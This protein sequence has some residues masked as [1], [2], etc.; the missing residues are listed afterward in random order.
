MKNL[1]IYLSITVYS[2]L[3]S[4]ISIFPV[5]TDL[6]VYLNLFI[7][8]YLSIHIFLPRSV[9][10]YLSISLSLSLSIYIYIYIYMYVFLYLFLSN[11]LI[12][13]YP[14]PS[15]HHS[16]LFLSPFYFKVSLFLLYFSL[17]PL[18]NSLLLINNPPFNLSFYPH[19]CQAHV[20][21]TKER[22]LG[23][24]I[25]LSPLSISETRQQ[26][27]LRLNAPKPTHP[28]F[29]RSETKMTKQSKKKKKKKNQI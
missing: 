21:N 3:S 8:I 17:F 5:H 20:P 18:C 10:I 24:N 22:N 12:F 14:L 6:S 15:L 16:H 25:Y 19:S 2:Y 7:L 23:G 9:T 26:F 27:S 1:S 29:D 11:I 4:N 13:I 28:C